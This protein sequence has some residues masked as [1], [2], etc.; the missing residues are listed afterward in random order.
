MVVKEEQE[1]QVGI[2]YVFSRFQ[3]NFVSF[4]FF[5]VSKNEVFGMSEQ[6][7]TCSNPIM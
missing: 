1:L 4:V 3:L 6:R 5:E 2:L 7:T